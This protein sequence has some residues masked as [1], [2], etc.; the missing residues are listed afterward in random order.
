MSDSLRELADTTHHFFSAWKSWVRTRLPESSTRALVLVSLRRMG[1]VTMGTISARLNITKSRLTAI[2]DE[3]E[4]EKLVKRATHPE[5]KRASVLTLTAKGERA[6]TE[7]SVSYDQE[8]AKL[9][10]V[11]DEKQRRALLESLHTLI[12]ATRA[13]KADT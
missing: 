2:V 9:F 10:E 3:L 5:D 6:A 7:A 13:L 11:L 8:V 12:N 1:A 4:D